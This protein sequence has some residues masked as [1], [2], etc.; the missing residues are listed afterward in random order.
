MLGRVGGVADTEEVRVQTS[1][2]AAQCVLCTARLCGLSTTEVGMHA[3]L[4]CYALDVV[5]RPAWLGIGT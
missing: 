1:S 3:C 2:C 5:A 4:C